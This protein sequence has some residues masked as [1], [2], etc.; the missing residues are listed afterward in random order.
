MRL[1]TN[2]ADQRKVLAQAISEWIHEPVRYEGVPSC[3]YAVGTV[4][5]ECGGVITSE[6][7]EAWAALQPFFED[8]GWME[9]TAQAD[10]PAAE[11][12]KAAPELTTDDCLISIPAPMNVA[13]L[14]NLVHMLYSQ[15][16][17]LNKSVMG[18][19]LTI[20]ESLIM[21]LNEYTPETPEAFAELLSDY[22]A[23]G[24]LEGFGYEN[25]TITMA[26]PFDEA[27]HEHL[28]IFSGLAERI[29][30]AAKTAKRVK[31]ELQT[32]QNEKYFM[33]S[34][35]LRLGYG[36]ADLKE[37]RRRLLQN[38]DGYS[39]FSNDANAEK[40]KEKYAAIRHAAREVNADAE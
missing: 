14:T 3:A 2:M 30:Q 5:V 40:H 1:E 8:H 31:A 17:L 11:D 25:D 9:E 6:D 24:E 20:P 15:Q 32:S 23:L 7:S 10:E 37:H 29:I 27:Q 35:L 28:T 16:H 34:W 19:R 13:Q 21:R 4:R 18:G 36:G 38:L 26:F 33:R 12:L 39:A 22:K